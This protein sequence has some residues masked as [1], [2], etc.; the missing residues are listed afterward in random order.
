MQLRH[1]VTCFLVRPDDG[2]VLLGERSEDVRTYPGHRAAISGSVEAAGPLEQAYREIEEETGLGRSD[3]ELRSEGWPVR[4]ADWDR[5]TV[6]VVHPYRFRCN[7]PEHV[8]R[9]WEHVRFDWVET[10]RISDVQTVPKL[11]EAWESADRQDGRPDP[12]WIFERVREDRD[13][14]ADE[15]GIWT[16][17]GLKRAGE[18][19]SEDDDWRESF[20]KACRRALAL[21]PGMAPVMAA[22][23]DACI[24][25]SEAESPGQLVG[26]LDELTAEREQAPL[27]AAE[28]AA[29]RIPDGAHVVT[30]SYSFSA[31]ATL[32][33][34]AEGVGRLTVAE[35]RPA[36]EGRRMAELA[37]SFGVETELVTDAVAAGTA[38]GTDLVLTG[39]DSLLPDGG[40][41]NKVGTFALCCAAARGA[42]RTLVVA[43]ESKVLPAGHEPGMEEMD[44]AELGASIPGVE[45][46]NVCFETVPADLIDE[47]VTEHGLSGPEFHA[48]RALHLMEARDSLS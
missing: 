2:R 20:R 48:H 45:T 11:A 14:G 10:R 36:C 5:G 25:A 16:L 21:R 3:V 4:F 7:A 27:R 23:L 24:L 13:H 8:R 6:W 34:A 47:I 38:R 32:Y 30:V 40:V 28:A 17:M 15:L 1:V 19:L 44:P 18:A 43:S 33:E 39:A 12:E 9:D 22:G 41:V 29:E 35:S 26:K 37:A 42:S 46:R 31:L